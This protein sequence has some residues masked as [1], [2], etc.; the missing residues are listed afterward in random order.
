MKRLVKLLL[1]IT[2]LLAG[3]QSGQAQSKEDRVEFIIKI[4][5]SMKTLRNHA[6]QQSDSLKVKNLVSQLVAFDTIPLVQKYL[7]YQLQQLAGIEYSSSADS[8]QRER[9]KSIVEHLPEDHKEVIAQ[10]E[11]I[12]MLMNK[13]IV[14]VDTS[15]AVWKRSSRYFE[16]Y[17][18]DIQPKQTV[19]EVGGGMGVDIMLMA[20]TYPLT[21]FIMNE[22]DSTSVNYVCAYASEMSINNLKV[23]LG[24]DS[25]THC[26]DSVD[27]VFVKRALHHFS[28]PEM[29]LNSIKSDM[30]PNAKL[31]LIENVL[32]KRRK[33][34]NLAMTQRAIHKV[35]RQSKFKR[36]EMYKKRSRLVETYVLR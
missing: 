17:T 32:N 11:R 26:Q 28:K 25:D 1:I 16:I 2:T 30:K 8:V 18:L 13:G 6:V 24:S 12:F 4:G 35:M 10:N 20:L 21:T 14:R 9:F 31:L 33:G 23:V 5:K 34:C 3:F 15:L 7:S 22:V 29:M 27:R 36:I 19:L